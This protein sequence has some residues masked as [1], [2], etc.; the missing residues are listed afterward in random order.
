MTFAIHQTVRNHILA[1]L[2]GH[3]LE[4]L[5]PHLTPVRLVAEQVLVEYK[6]RTEHVFFVEEGIISLVAGASW[7]LPSFQVAMIG[8]EGLVGCQTLLGTHTESF[9]LAMVQFPGIAHRMAVADLLQIIQ[10]CPVLHGLCMHAIEDLIDQT[11]QTAAFS[12]RNTLVKRCA[13]WLLMAHDRVTGDDLP[14]THETMAGL[15]GVRR[16]GITVV[17]AGLQEAGLVRVHRGRITILE[18]E[19]LERLTGPKAWTVDPR[20]TQ[21]PAWRTASAAGARNV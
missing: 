20:L 17:A 11:M 16:S 12:A 9:S 7:S 21:A 10:E 8:V 6:Q 4:A 14:V 1:A 18:R 5:R 15:L 19:G 13:R 3:E 2:P